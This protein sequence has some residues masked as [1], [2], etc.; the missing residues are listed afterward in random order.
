MKFRIDQE[1]NLVISVCTV[2]NFKFFGI[3]LERNRD[4]IFAWI[5]S[6]LGQKFKDTLKRFV[7]RRCCQ[8][9]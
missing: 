1:R 6:K 7:S 9:I 3:V 8:S 2:Q 5:H 4:D